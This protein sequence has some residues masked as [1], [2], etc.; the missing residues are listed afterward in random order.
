MKQSHKLRLETIYDLP[1][2]NLYASSFNQEFQQNS[3]TPSR[4]IDFV[5]LQLKSKMSIKA[6]IFV[7]IFS[8]GLQILRHLLF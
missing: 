2:S 6:E 8:F 4:S 5:L 7:P 1:S 3:H